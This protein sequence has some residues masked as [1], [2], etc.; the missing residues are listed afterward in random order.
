MGMTDATEVRCR[1]CERLRNPAARVCPHCGAGVSPTVSARYVCPACLGS[2]DPPGPCARCGFKGPLVDRQHPEETAPGAVAEGAE[3]VAPLVVAIVV[4]LAC[5][6]VLLA[7]V[8]A[9]SAAALRW[10]G[11]PEGQA[12]QWAWAATA[13]VAAVFVWLYVNRLVKRIRWRQVKVD[14]DGVTQ[15]GPGPRIVQLLWQGVDSCR[16]ERTRFGEIE[17]DTGLTGELVVS[18]AGETIR[19]WKSMKGYP[20]GKRAILARTPVATAWELPER[21]SRFLVWLVIAI[22]LIAGTI[23]VVWWALKWL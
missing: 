1:V 13:V 2:Q 14:R 20:E 4:A 10:L 18:R 12:R 19:I 7:G 9:G 3:P 23:L 15:T 16:L 17:L 22:I 11:L 21:W 5:Q 6:S 8:W